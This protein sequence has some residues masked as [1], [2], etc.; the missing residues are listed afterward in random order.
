MSRKNSHARGVGLMNFDNQQSTPH[1]I[2]HEHH[3]DF[4]IDEEFLN[5]DEFEEIAEIYD[6]IRLLH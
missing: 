2:E 1:N 5:P 6:S 4:M 3:H